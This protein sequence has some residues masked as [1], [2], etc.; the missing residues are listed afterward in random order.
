MNNNDDEK[1]MNVILKDGLV[2]SDIYMKN[3]TLNELKQKKEEKILNF[4]CKRFIVNGS[5]YIT[6]EMYNRK[7]TKEEEFVKFKTFTEY[8]S[9]VK[10]L[11]VT[12]KEEKI[13][14]KN[15]NMIQ[16]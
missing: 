13:K 6:K 9:G 2:N 7:Q 4:P 11:R 15:S 8:F 16:K 3:I 5:L 1:K 12:N 10:S 14:I